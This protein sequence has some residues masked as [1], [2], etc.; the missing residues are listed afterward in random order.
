MIWGVFTLPMFPYCSRQSDS[1]AGSFGL[2]A[3][4][5]VVTGGDSSRETVSC[6]HPPLT[7]ISVGV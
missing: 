1:N 3:T 7:N 2:Q 6:L 5:S 4:V